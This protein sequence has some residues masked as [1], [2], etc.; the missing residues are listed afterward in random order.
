ML[1]NWIR[2]VSRQITDEFVFKLWVFVQIACLILQYYKCIYKARW[3]SLVVTEFQIEHKK[4]RGNC[5]KHLAGQ[6]F[7][8]GPSLLNTLHD[9]TNMNNMNS[10][11]KYKTR[12]P[13]KP[14][15]KLV[16][17]RSG[18]RPAI[19]MGQITLYF[20]AMSC[21]NFA[22]ITPLTGIYALKYYGN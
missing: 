14:R 4:M 1:L 9:N 12:P 2:C 21:E 16:S 15:S 6:N 8:K 10:Q 19:I 7:R 13:P 11:P 3:N 17:A 20:Y 5:S 22:R 18:S